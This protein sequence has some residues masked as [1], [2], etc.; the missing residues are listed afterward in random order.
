MGVRGFIKRISRRVVQ[1]YILGE[2]FGV[3]PGKVILENDRHV[4]RYREEEEREQYQKSPY[5]LRFYLSVYIDNHKK[6][7]RMRGRL[8]NIR[9][10]HVDF[11]NE[12]VL[13]PQPQLKKMEE[14]MLKKRWIIPVLKIKC[15][16]ANSLIYD[17]TL[18][19]DAK[20]DSRNYV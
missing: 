17:P 13:I 5:Y 20:G 3:R 18:Y 12:L 9:T 15:K 19:P 11:Y 4:N 7:G 2:D 1:V 10:R 14:V 6:L 8:F 16:I